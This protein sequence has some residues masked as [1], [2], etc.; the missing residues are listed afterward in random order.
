MLS[1][2]VSY[3]WKT[4]LTGLIHQIVSK[5]DPSFANTAWKVAK[6]K[7]NLS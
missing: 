7:I 3:V 1:G 2:E 5:L 4:L 6:S